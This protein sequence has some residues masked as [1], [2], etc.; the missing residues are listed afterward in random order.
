MGKGRKGREGKERK[1]GVKWEGEEPLEPKLSKGTPNTSC[2]PWWKRCVVWLEGDHPYEI[3]ATLR[4]NGKRATV[5]TTNANHGV[6][7]DAN[8]NALPCRVHCRT[9]M[10]ACLAELCVLA[11]RTSLQHGRIRRF[12]GH[13]T[14][15]FANI[16]KSVITW[17]TNI[18]GVCVA[19]VYTFCT[20][21]CTLSI[22]SDALQYRTKKT[23]Y[24][25]DAATKTKK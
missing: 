2:R 15:C 5:I 6:G 12:V 8:Y 4:C 25:P 13:G 17:C 7:S 1:Q 22:H 18:T 3:D 24:R 23:K 11:V 19:R 21:E 20:P 10:D 9:D 16:C 14:G